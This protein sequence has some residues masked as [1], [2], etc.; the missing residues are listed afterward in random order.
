MS[1]LA[2]RPR[3]ALA[4]EVHGGAGHRQPSLV[5][6]D[7]VAD[8]IG[9]GDRAMADR[10]AERPAGDGADVL[11]EL[12]DRGA[13][14]RPVPGIVHPRRDLVDQHLRPAACPAPR[15]SRP[16]ARRHSRARWRSSPR[17]TRASA[18]SASG[19]SAGAREIFRMWSRCSF[20]VTSKHSTWPS[21]ERAAITEISRSNGTK[22]SRIAD[23]C[24]DRPR[25]ARRSSPSRMIA[26]PLPS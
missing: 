2:A 1:H 7:V 11:L 22:A 6:E 9:H 24:R 18:A 17:S 10:L 8:Q 14:E 25:S 15:T 3:R 26:W 21:A 16:R 20:S 12:R 5:V 4:V 19:I 13:V 23:W